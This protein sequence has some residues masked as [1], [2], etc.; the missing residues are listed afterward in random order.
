M[1]GAR[2]P[3]TEDRWA[4]LRATRRAQGLCM[5]WGGKWSRDH[6]CPPTVQ[7]HVVQELLDVFQ[8]NEAPAPDEFS[9]EPV[10]EKLFLSLSVAAVLG[11]ITP[12]TLCFWGQVGEQ[13]V[14]ILLDSG[15]SHTFISPAVAAQCS[16][17]QQLLPPLTVQVANG[18]VLTCSAHVPNAVWS[19]QNC[20]FQTDLKVLPLSSYDMILGLDWLEAYSPME[21]DWRQ[22]WLHFQH[23]GASAY[24]IGILPELPADAVF[25]LYS[26]ELSPSSGTP[27][28][29]PEIEQ[30]LHQFS[31]LFDPPSQLPPSRSCDH[32]IPLV[33]GAAPVFSRPYRFSPTIKDEVEKQVKEMLST[34]I[35]QKSSSPYSSPVLLVKKK[36]N[37][38][39]FCVDYRQL[40]AITVKSKYPVPIIDELLDELG[41][42]TWFSKLDLRSG[43]HQI[44]L[45]PGEEFKTAFQTHF[46]HFEFRVMPFGLNGAPGTFQ[47]AMN[48]TLAP[49]LRKFILVFFDDILVF[50]PSYA[51]HLNHLQLVFQQLHDHDW[52]IKLS[53]CEFAQRSITYLGHV[54]S[55]AGVATDPQKVSAVVHWPAPSS[56]K[57]LRGFLGLAGYYRKFV[58]NFGIIAKPLTE[59]LKKN[60]VIL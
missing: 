19:I 26:S 48:S 10:N 32:S 60:S 30:L 28:W 49:F 3:S 46:G 42:A 33:A 59:L 35:I 44:L 17:L 53:K 27:S 1:D 16:S 23:E 6:Q 54:I 37:S 38:W 8:L 36:D 5:H 31:R 40:N 45:K 12:R 15:S 20:Q 50:S 21:I 18:Q 41:G 56:V 57:E 43:F 52:K 51:D 29:P 55:E 39:R 4:A 24:L 13:Q 58:R 11:F 22:K 25:Q 14:R 34:G 2:G 7:L 9:D 47:D